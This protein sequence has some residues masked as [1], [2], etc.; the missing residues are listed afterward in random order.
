M[1]KLTVA[2]LTCL[3]LGVGLMVALWWLP[4]GVSLVRVIVWV[5]LGLLVI[6]FGQFQR[7][8]PRLF[9]VLSVCYYVLT[10]LSLGASGFQWKML[11]SGVED[12][13]S[14][15]LLAAGAVALI[16]W[17]IVGDDDSPKS[18]H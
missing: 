3:I 16:V 12:A 14:G 1:K 7:E 10:W 18:D 11:P 15:F 9:V 17:G 5:C 2:W 6:P 13:I 4:R 8:Y